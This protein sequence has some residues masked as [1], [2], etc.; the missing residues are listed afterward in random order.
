[1]LVLHHITQLAAGGVILPPGGHHTG[2]PTVRRHVDLLLSPHTRTHTHTHTHTLKAE[3]L[4]VND[5][6]RIF[7]HRC[8]LCSSADLQLCVLETYKL[9]FH[10]RCAPN[11]SAI[12]GCLRKQ[13][14]LRGVHCV[15]ITQSGLDYT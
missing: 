1:M 3:L 2:S 8:L 4:I 5:M 14:G 9:P 7:T 12:F 15:R 11:Q 10:P 6:S 13:M